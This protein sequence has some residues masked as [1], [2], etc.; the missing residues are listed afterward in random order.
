VHRACATSIVVLAVIS[1]SDCGRPKGRSDSA[2]GVAAL[3]DSLPETDTSGLAALS[4]PPP[5]REFPAT[6]GAP[7]ET[8]PARP[9]GPGNALGI[10]P[11]QGAD[12]LRGIVRIVGS[13]A[14][15]QVIVRPDAG[16]PMVT[17]LG[18]QATMLGRLSG[19]DVWV[20]GV[21]NSARSLTVDRFLVRAVDGIPAMD[22]K[23]V[24]RDGGVAIVTTA[25]HAEHPIVN[26]PS[27]LRARV[28]SRVWLKG[29]LETGAVTFGVI[30]DS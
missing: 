21:R 6:S 15:E 14:D 1:V 22:G 12:T 20:S 19:V 25:D 9:S 27:A 24:S 17:L 13:A 4:A 7:E 5:G 10:K 29:T 30:G 18:D 3:D 16:G 2:N 28:G 11:A 26:P 23:L 8:S